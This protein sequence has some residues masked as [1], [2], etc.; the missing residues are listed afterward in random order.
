MKIFTM[1]I[2]LAA[3][4]SPTL[5]LAQKPASPAGG[6]TS[7]IAMLSGCVSADPKARK[8]FTLSDATQDQTYRLTGIDVR[9]YGRDAEAIP[10]RGGTI[11]ER[12]CGGA[13]GLH[14]S[15]EGGDGGAQWT[16]GQLA[17]AAHRVQGEERPHYA[18]RLRGSVADIRQT[19]GMSDIAVRPYIFAG[20]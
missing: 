16:G 15:D 2:C 20:P 10:C 6:K 11:S 8:T 7:D 18:R 5:V 1:F 19:P 17:S 13:S 12:E 4:M 14:R 9:D 3:A